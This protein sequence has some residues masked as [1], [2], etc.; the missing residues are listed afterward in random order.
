MFTSKYKLRS[1]PHLRTGLNNRYDNSEISDTDMAD[2]ENVEVDTKSIRNAGGYVDYGGATGPFWGGIHAVFSG[3]TNRLIRQRGATLEYDSD[4]AG[5]WV[6]CTL[7]TAG[8]PAE[9]V[10]LTQEPC[11]MAML[12]DTVMWSNG[13]DVVMSSTDGITWELEA[14]LPK[15][16]V[17]FNNGLNRMLYMAVPTTP[18]KV[19]WSDIN[20]PTTVGASSY[21]FIN[22][23]DGQEIMDAVLMPNGAM[24][25][26]KTNRF[27]QISD[28]TFDMTSVD[29]IGEA[30][31]VRGT[32]CATENSAI[33]AG[34]DGRIYEFDGGKANLISDQIVNS[35]E[36]NI[37]IST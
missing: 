1:I 27:Y 21:Q 33:W 15:A 2:C 11:S 19:E 6:E 9:T 37:V 4:G 18:S 13:T 20:D 5:T 3:G 14:L 10:V 29:P 24:L 28:I 8:S 17:L 22:P 30:P 35:S 7:P 26:L 32:A 23:N 36:R 12:N 16:R 31:C 25:L 34:P